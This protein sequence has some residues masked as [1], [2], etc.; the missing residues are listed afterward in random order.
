[1]TGKKVIIY[2]EMDFE[3]RFKQKCTISEFKIIGQQA[4][5]TMIANLE[6]KYSIST[7]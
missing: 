6:K 7:F 1:M 4:T 5:K 2:D 3:I